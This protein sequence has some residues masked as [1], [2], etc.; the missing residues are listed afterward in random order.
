MASSSSSN[1]AHASASRVWKYDVFLSFRGEDTRNTFVDHLH[2][3][4]VQR[5]IR[6]YKDDEALLRGDC[7]GPSLFKAI[8]ESHI[9]VIVFSKNYADSS[10]CLDELSYIMKCMDEK[11]LIVMPI[12]YDVDPSQV[13]NQEG[14]FGEA[15]AKQ[16]AKNVTKAE[17]WR[18]TLFDASNIAGWEPKHVANG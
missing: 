8:E 15:F 6:V 4:L 17:L 18:K 12:F 9:A 2:S 11:G 10:W 5:I 16:E 13:R 7:I 14:N 1:S 3:A